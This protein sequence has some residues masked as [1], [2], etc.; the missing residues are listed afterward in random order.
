MA[1]LPSRFL[2][3]VV[4]IGITDARRRTGYVATGF[5][6][7]QAR[8]RT[9]DGKVIYRVFL[10]TN[11]H[12][13]ASEKAV[14]LRVNM[15]RDEP[16]NEYHLTLIGRFG[17]R[18]WC[19]HP[20]PD[21]DI[22]VACPLATKLR[23]E[24]VRFSYFREDVD[25]ANMA[26]CTAGGVSEGDP[27]LILGFP[28]G[29]VG[30]PENFVIVRHGSI[31]RIRDTLIGRSNDLVLD[32]LVFPGNSGG[33]VVIGPG[34]V[35]AKLSGVPLGFQLI[36]VVKSYTAY[37]SWVRPKHGDRVS[38]VNEQNSGLAQAHPVDFITSAL[39]GLN[40]RIDRLPNPACSDDVWSEP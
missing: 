17:Q 36:G 18:L 31:A 25:T 33:P 5:F 28:M 19:P 12:V 23:K 1:L 21:I 4:A 20:T 14:T 34:V 8:G 27:V 35:A 22:A 38:V 13:L 39:L 11:R 9:S 24:G 15:L 6:Y 40:E 10:V 7:G 2:D 37:T 32:A 29:D 16:A 30:K 26:S 3:A